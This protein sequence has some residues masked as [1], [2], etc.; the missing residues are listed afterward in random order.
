MIG[1]HARARAPAREGWAKFSPGTTAVCSLRDGDFV[2][3]AGTSQRVRTLTERRMD[4][5]LYG[6]MH[7]VVFCAAEV[8][9]YQASLQVAY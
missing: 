1:K 6:P 3:P 4:R 9:G 8:P 5:S 2:I 7:R